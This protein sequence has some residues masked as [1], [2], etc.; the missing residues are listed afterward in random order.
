MEITISVPDE[1]GKEINSLPGRD[2]LELTE[3]IS[4]LEKYRQSL[5]IS[6]TSKKEYNKKTGKWAKFSEEIKKN[7]SLYRG[8]SEKIQKDSKEFR[9]NFVFNEEK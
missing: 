8:V 5:I 1:V 6:P 2:N 3:L 4:M 7:S 9:E